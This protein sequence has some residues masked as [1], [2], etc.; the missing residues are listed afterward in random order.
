MIC[1]MPSIQQKF[2]KNFGG[3]QKPIFLKELQLQLNGTQTIQNGGK[4]LSKENTETTTKICMEVN[5][6]N[7]N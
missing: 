3:I 2:I 4:T 1:G 6:S 7:C 5:N